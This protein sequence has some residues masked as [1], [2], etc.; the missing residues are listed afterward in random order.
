MLKRYFLKKILKKLTVKKK[1]KFLVKNLVLSKVTKHS[2]HNLYIFKKINSIKI[3]IHSVAPEMCY[4][5]KAE[6]DRCETKRND[7]LR[8]ICDSDQLERIFPRD[9]YYKMGPAYSLNNETDIMWEIKN[10]GPVQGMETDFHG[11]I[12]AIKIYFLLSSSFL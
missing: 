12:T 1:F 6:V 2:L 10:Y 7:N 3:L 5:Y 4:E 8:A 11:I 9:Y